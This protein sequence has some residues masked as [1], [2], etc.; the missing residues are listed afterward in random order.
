MRLLYRTAAL[1]EESQL[2]DMKEIG[3]S[4]YLLCGCHGGFHCE[5]VL[6]VKGF[7]DGMEE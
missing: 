2:N 5:D 7:F 1:Y 4:F 6:L 3:G